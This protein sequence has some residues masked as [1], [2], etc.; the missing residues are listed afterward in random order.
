[1]F[2]MHCIAGALTRRVRQ[3]ARSMPYSAVPYTSTAM[4]KTTSLRRQECICINQSCLASV[5][6][7]S[8]PHG[9]P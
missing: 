5:M 9:L 8:D 4:H 2:Q 7:A 3:I 6:I 1:M